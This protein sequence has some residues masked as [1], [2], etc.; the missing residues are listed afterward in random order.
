M[1]EGK[2]C[3]LC[4]LRIE[5]E[6]AQHEQ[7]KYHDH[8]AREVKNHNSVSTM[9]PEPRKE[10]MRDYMRRYRRECK[11]RLSAGSSHNATATSKCVIV[12]PVIVSSLFWHFVPHL[13]F[14]SVLDFIRHLRV[15]VL[16]VTA[17]GIGVTVAW[18]RL[19]R[20]WKK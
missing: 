5:T 18:R 16:E 10:Y 7:T 15:L 14:E 1:L 20:L 8:C 4:K 17:L 11:A 19:R 6:K 3:E 2:R 13:S 9:L 12:A